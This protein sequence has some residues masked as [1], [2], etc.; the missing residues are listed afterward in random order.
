MRRE[1]HSKQTCRN[2]HN[3]S[4]ILQTHKPTKGVGK[5]KECRKYPPLDIV[6]FLLNISKLRSCKSQ[7]IESK[8]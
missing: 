1:L 2:F 6:D 8:Q 3:Y 7:R 5:E 4:T